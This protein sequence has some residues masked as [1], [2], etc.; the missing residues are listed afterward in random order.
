VEGGAQLAAALRR[1]DLVDRIVWFHAPTVMGAD[2]W[3]SAQAFG[4][5]GLSTMPRFVRID[6]RPV[7]EDMMTELRKAA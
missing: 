1:A 7:G 6:A 5:A 3:P 2:G 4:T